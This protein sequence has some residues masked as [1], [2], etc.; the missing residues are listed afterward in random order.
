VQHDLPLVPLALSCYWRC[1]E[2]TTDVKVDYQY[3]PSCLS[4]ISPLN[5]V[6]VVVPVNGGVEIMQSKPMAKW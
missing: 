5:N 3:T 2:K 1:E 4:A 6:S